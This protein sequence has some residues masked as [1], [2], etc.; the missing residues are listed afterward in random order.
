MYKKVKLIYGVGINDLDYPISAVVDGKRTMCKFYQKYIGMLNRAYSDKRSTSTGV[1]DEWKY[2]SN[3]KCWMEQQ[4]WVG[5]QLDKDILI[6]GNK[7]Y[8]PEACCFVPIRINNVLNHRARNG[9]CPIG[10]SRKEKTDRCV[11]PLKRQYVASITIVDTNGDKKEISLGYHE[12]PEEAHKKWQWAKAY[13]IE[14]AVSWYSTQDCFRTDVAEALMGR[15]WKLRLDSANSV[16]T[17]N[18]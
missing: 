12:T 16:E 1:C 14:K 9:A 11:N 10:V 17:K 4:D 15:V 8:S 18:I 6:V 7:I 3:F 5:L 2:A 13:E